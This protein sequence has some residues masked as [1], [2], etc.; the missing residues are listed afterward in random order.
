MLEIKHGFCV[1][2]IVHLTYSDVHVHHIYL[3]IYQ[4]Y[5]DGAKLM[6]ENALLLNILYFEYFNV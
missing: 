1:L 3:I 2:N 6:N 4:Y 5:L